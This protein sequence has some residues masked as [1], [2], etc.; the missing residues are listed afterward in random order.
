MGVGE[1]DTPPASSSYQDGNTARLYAYI[2][3]DAAKA[4]VLRRGPSRLVLMLVWD[5]ESDTFEDGQWFKGRI[6]ERRCDLSPCAEHFVY[7][8]GKHSGEYGTYT[9][10]STPPYFSAHVLWPKG[11]CWGGGGLFDAT[12]KTL[13][14]N[15]STEWNAQTKTWGKAFPKP[16]GGPA[17][18]AL[19]PPYENIAPLGD[20]PGCGEDFPIEHARMTRDGWTFKNKGLKTDIPR[21][22]QPV[23]AP[24]EAGVAF[25]WHT[26]GALYWRKTAQ[27]GRK[28]TLIQDQAGQIDGRQN[29]I[30]CQ[31][32]TKDGELFD[33]KRVDWA[34]FDKNND[35]LYA[36]NGCF[37]RVK[38][39]KENAPHCLIDLNDRTFKA[40]MPPE[41]MAREDRRRANTDQSS[42][43]DLPNTGWHP[44]DDD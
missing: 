28:L 17:F 9:V 16:R 12:T 21:N 14:L 20:Y 31:L 33:Y 44:L 19:P 27:D 22:W 41:G 18:G 7:F 26:E 32:T 37:Y 30:T 38:P 42:R 4:V 25:R 6:Y 36:R 15:H 40:V 3:R 5:M 34:D 8:A 43:E 23:R 29:I 2:A 24:D 13:H 39:G 1:E 35:L 11:D 10:V